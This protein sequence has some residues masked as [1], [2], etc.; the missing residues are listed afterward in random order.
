MVLMEF[1]SLKTT[2]ALVSVAV[3]VIDGLRRVSAQVAVR[4]HR[5]GQSHRAPHAAKQPER[6]LSHPTIRDQARFV[7]SAGKC[8]S[9]T[10]KWEIEILTPAF[11][12]QILTRYP[13]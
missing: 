4:R 11:A 8:K 13:S 10:C 6:S 7:A 1:P 5:Q 9:I 12:G 2:A 3:K